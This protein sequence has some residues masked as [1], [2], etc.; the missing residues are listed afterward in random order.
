MA[1]SRPLVGEYGASPEGAP[2]I[3]G[4]CALIAVSLGMG[5]VVGVLVSLLLRVMNIGVTFMWDTLPISTTCLTVNGNG[6][7]WD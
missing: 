2:R 6:G 4:I 3:A 1:D 7:T 5:L